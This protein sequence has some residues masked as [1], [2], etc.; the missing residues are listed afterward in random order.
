MT[1]C[2]LLPSGLS[3]LCRPVTGTGWNGKKGQRAGGA[4]IRPLLKLKHVRIIPSL[5][6]EADGSNLLSARVSAALRHCQSVCLSAREASFLLYA[7]SIHL[8]PLRSP[9]LFPSFSS[10]TSIPA[11]SD[12][13][14][15][16]NGLNFEHLGR[17][18]NVSVTLH[19]NF[20]SAVRK[21]W[22]S[23]PP[24]PPAL[25]CFLGNTVWK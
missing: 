22:S 24:P 15:G 21:L 16:G 4:L 18:G 3:D 8:T 6:Q 7:R 9:C 25:L 13:D 20:H 12:D 11:P 5:R 23:E 19:L 14:P 2:L 17:K 1:V 10:N